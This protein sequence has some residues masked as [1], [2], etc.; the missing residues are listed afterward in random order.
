MKVTQTS[1]CGTPCRIVQVAD[2]RAD[3]TLYDDGRISGDFHD[4]ESF[5]K[6]GQMDSL[7]FVACWSILQEWKR[8]RE[9]DGAEARTA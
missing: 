5:L 7:T 1:V 6:Y 3:L 8:Q 9:Q 2:D 4:F